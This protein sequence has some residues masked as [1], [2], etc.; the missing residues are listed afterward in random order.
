[1]SRMSWGRYPRIESTVL[2]F[3]TEESL[4]KIVAEHHD[5][6]PY[7]N[8]R[9]Y[10]DS[11]LNTNIINVRPHDYFINFNEESGLLN[12][13]AG[14]LLAEI[15]ESFVSR[16]WFLKITP[17]TKFITVGGAIA[18]DVHGKN[19]H[20]EGCFS[21]CIEDFKMMV[22]DGKVVTCSKAATP[23]LFKATCGGQGLTGVILSAR[24]Y[25]KKIKS[26]HID[27]TTVKTSSLKETFDA[28]EE[29]KNYPYS[30]AWIDCLAKGND[31]GR[32]LLMVG[33][34]MD[35]GN[36]DYQ[37][38]QKHSIPFNFP[39][40]TL[41]NWSVRAFNW[42]YYG[43]VKKRISKQ[44][45]NIDTFFYPLDAIGHWN[46]IYGK[47]GFT[48]YQ[49]ILPK[50]HSYKGL[51]EALSTIASS[52]KGSFLAVLKLYGKANENY[53]SFP[54]EGYSL[55]LDFKIEKGLFELLDMLDRIVVKYGGRIYLTKD[56]R[57]SKGVFERGYPQVDT[58]RQFRKDNG[59][60]RKFQ[61]LQSKRVG[62]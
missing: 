55:A 10:G 31:I 5:L 35:D 14:V 50:E 60:D 20:A 54:M 9:S 44:K 51:Q 27:Q 49:F 46:R 43:K 23:E 29:Y 32:C 24:I 33:D 3:D 38:K 26:K 22:A 1:M 6:I 17:G 16:G 18:S 30:V 36:L 41:S 61:S 53:L 52:G 19:H 47:Q 15:L 4:Q 62:I 21:E 48:Q 45:V 13:Q 59:M 2:R 37:D 7:G 12:V 8:G 57:V 34:F 58:F 56:V 11:A 28:F 25:L 39:S 42:L 40:F